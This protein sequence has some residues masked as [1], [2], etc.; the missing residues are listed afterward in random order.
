MYFYFLYIYLPNVFVKCYS[1][2]KYKRKTTQSLTLEI[3]EKKRN[4]REVPAEFQ[5]CYVTLFKFVQKKEAG[6]PVEVGY[7]KT[8]LVFTSEQEKGSQPF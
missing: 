1:L 8:R 3:M 6:V 4:Y 2:R 7:K 5:L